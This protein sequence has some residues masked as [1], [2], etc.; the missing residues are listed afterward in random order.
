ME[1]RK[2]EYF[3][4]C[5]ITSRCGKQVNDLLDGLVGLMIRGFE[6]AFRPVIGVGLVMEATIG[7]RAA[8]TLVEEQE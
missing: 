7:E 5:R 4:I 1:D 6:F 2:Q 8:E 3:N